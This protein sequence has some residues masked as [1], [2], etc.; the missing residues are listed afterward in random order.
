MF[1]VPRRTSAASALAPEMGGS[2][3][4][5]DSDAVPGADDDAELCPAG[6]QRRKQVPRQ[7]QE[8]FH[9]SRNSRAATGSEVYVHGCRYT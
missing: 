8:G 4:T 9:R 2:E 5:R 6:Q 7:Q 1:L 3:H